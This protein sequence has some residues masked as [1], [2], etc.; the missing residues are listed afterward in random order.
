SLA[1]LLWY[2]LA[3][4]RW[5][6]EMPWMSRIGGPSGRPHSRTCSR[7]PAPPCTVCTVIGS[8]GFCSPSDPGCV[9]VVI[10]RLLG[11]GAVAAGRTGPRREHRASR[12]AAATS[13]SVVGRYNF[14]SRQ[15]PV[16]AVASAMGR[17]LRGGERDGWLRP[18]LPGGQG[19]GTAGRTL[20]DAGRPRAAAR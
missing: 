8:V 5:L 7:R 17:S 6:A 14:C 13:G 12:T 15:R 18:V 16:G 11:V 20:D 1:S 3:Q 2:C 10:S 19:D 9:I 4:H